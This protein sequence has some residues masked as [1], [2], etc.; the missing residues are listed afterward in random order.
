MIFRPFTFYDE[1]NS[2]L[3]KNNKNMLTYRINKYFCKVVFQ[4]LSMGFRKI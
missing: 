4:I 2:A 3:K 1:K